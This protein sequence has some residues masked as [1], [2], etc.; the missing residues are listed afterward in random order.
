MQTAAALGAASVGSIKGTVSATTS[1]VSA[2]PTLLAGARLKLVNRDLPDKSFQ[3]VTD[4]AGNFSFNDLPTATY[5]LSAEADGFPSVTREINLTAGATLNV[6]ILLTA[7]LTESVTV[8]DDEGLLS[9]GETTTTNTIRAQTL[10]NVPLRAENFQSALLLTPG[11]V[12]DAQGGDHLKGA[13]TGQSAYTLNG[14]D[15]TDPVSGN[16]AFDI[17]LEAAAAVQIEENPYSA[18]FGHLTGGA[19]NLETKGG[20]NKFKLSATRFFPVFH[21]IFGG[22]VD[23]FRPR[24]TMSGHL[25]RDRLFFLQ[26]FEYRFGRSYVPSLAAGRDSSTAENFNSFTQ[27]D[28]IANKSNRFKFV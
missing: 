18:E 21:H 10:V 6:E 14:V 20:S 11:V 4:E 2:R 8:R 28:L 12:R 15:V 7:S 1:D 27:L 23:S 25:V 19:T 9:T 16:L 26:S 17:P 24:V 13:R 5:L 22:A 3:T